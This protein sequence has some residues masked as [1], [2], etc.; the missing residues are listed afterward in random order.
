MKLGILVF[1]L[2]A[3]WH[4][5]RGPEPARWHDSTKPAA[6]LLPAGAWLV[7]AF[8]LDTSQS[9]S[10]HAAEA[11]ARAGEIKN[12]DGGCQV[13]M[14]HVA[15]AV[16]GHQHYGFVGRGVFQ[17][18]AM[19]TCLASSLANKDGTE[20]STIAGHEALLTKGAEPF[21][22]VVSDHGLFVAATPSI[23]ERMLATPLH[24]VTEDPALAPLIARARAGGELWAAARF[25]HDAPYVTDVLDLLAV[26]LTGH[27][28]A[29]VAFIHFTAPFKISVEL[30]LEQAGDAAA[31]ATALGQRKRA[32]VALDPNLASVLDAIAVARDGTRVRL[33]GQ[34]AQIDWMKTL[35]G[36]LAAVARLRT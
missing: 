18:D 16:Y 20:Q 26:K 6:E 7:V 17:P 1:L 35:Q 34:F 23:I 2:S 25:P 19:L 13:P 4:S 14:N 36:L 30:E 24:P 22:F 29:L 33:D 21:G 31:L 15:F 8:D 3:C 32:L 28:A 27:V 12:A 9:P 10:Q 5:S 11:K